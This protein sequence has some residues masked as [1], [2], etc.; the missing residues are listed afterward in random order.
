LSDVAG[1]D[2]AVIASGPFA[3]DPSSY[4]DALAILAQRAI[5][6]P[7]SVR[8]HLLAGAAGDIAETPKPGAACFRRVEQ[9]V[10]GNGRT[11]LLAAARYFE[12]R[13]VPAV[14]LGDT[15]TGE[16]REVAQ[17][18]AA[19]AREVSRTAIP[20]RRRWYCCPAAKPVSR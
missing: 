2:P 12:L 1:D 3:A 18:F 17:V 6:A 20:G 4:A 13:G 19:L 7:A 14:I 15:H 11:A 9:H 5:T 10:I 8:R 16:A